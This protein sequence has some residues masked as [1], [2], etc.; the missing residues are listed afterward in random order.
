MDVLTD[1]ELQAIAEEVGVE[2]GRLGQYLGFPHHKVQFY[3][4]R[5][6]MTWSFSG[7]MELL[8]CWRRK[9]RFTKDQRTVL[10]SSL[11]AAGLGDLADRIQQGEF[12]AQGQNTDEYA[13]TRPIATK[14]VLVY[15]VYASS[16]FVPIAST[17]WSVSCLNLLFLPVEIKELRGHLISYYESS[18]CDLKTVPW[19]SSSILKLDELYIN[20]NLLN[21][22]FNKGNGLVRKPI[23]HS[24]LFD[25]KAKSGKVAKRVLITGDAGT[26]KTTLSCKIAHDW[27]RCLWGFSIRC[28]PIVILLQLRLVDPKNSLGQEIL[29]QGLVP[30]DRHGTITADLID[31]YV[32]RNPENAIII[33]DGYD[34][35]VDGSLKEITKGG[36]FDI[37]RYKSFRNTIVLVTCRPWRE[38]DFDDIPDYTH[39]EL[40][41][42]NNSNVVAFVKNFF[43][44]NE[45]KSDKLLTWL[46][47][48]EYLES[49]DRLLQEPEAIT[50]DYD[51]SNCSMKTVSYMARYPLFLTMFC[52]LSKN[53]DFL[54]ES[55]KVSDVFNHIIEYMYEQYINK[56]KDSRRVTDLV[57]FDCLKVNLGK[58]AYEGFQVQTDETPKEKTVFTV[59][60]FENDTIFRLGS[61]IGFLTN[62]PEHNYYRNIMPRRK[63]YTTEFFHKFAQGYFASCYLMHIQKKAVKRVTPGGRF[64]VQSYEPPS[65]FYGIVGRLDK[66]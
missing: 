14:K 55:Y 50:C 10:M 41:G 19:N 17:I 38:A 61:E 27:S 56:I 12:I 47:G 16:F 42:F 25:L 26:G 8:Y 39:I 48:D 18:V 46:F 43:G 33:F 63:V 66:N 4:L 40:T 6:R 20:L 30:T 31:N 34:E 58:P 2:I 29:N 21:H 3:Q 59:E 45:K 52:E 36:I 49:A 7:T 44:H 35:Y 24:E 13:S 15:M 60:E 64:Y 23:S 57:D 5:N 62:I 37:L 65:G 22:D 28:T 9:T 32:S 53:E 1:I 54:V 51:Y 11:S